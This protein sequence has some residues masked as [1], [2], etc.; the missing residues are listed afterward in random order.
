MRLYVSPGSPF[1]RTCRIVA[2]EKGLFDRLEE[3]LVDPYANPPELV[4]ANPIAQVPAL[5][6]DDGLALTDSAVIC[7]WLEAHG[8]GPRLLPDGPDRW[9][10]RRVATLANGALEMGVKLLLETRRP[11]NER[12]SSW[13]SRWTINLNRALDALEAEAPGAGP[14][15]IGVIAAAVAATW[16]GFRHPGLDWASGRPALTALQAKLETRSSFVETFPR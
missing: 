3:V 9:R 15:D 14:L 4:A 8:S 1:A 11:E 7:E 10:V 5:V 16:L 6:T 12:S 13:M 2:R